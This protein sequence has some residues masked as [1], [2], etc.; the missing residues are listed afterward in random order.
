MRIEKINE[1]KIK[2]LIDDKEAEMWNVSFKKISQNT[3]EAQRVLWTAIRAAE[4][5][6]HFSVAGAKLFVEAVEGDMLSKFGMLI[7]KVANEEELND[8]IKN[9]SYKGTLRRSRL[10]LG[11]ERRDNQFIYRFCDFESVCNAA[12]EIYSIYSGESTLYKYN[13]E[14]YLHLIPAEVEVSPV[15]NILTEFG[16]CVKN[17][18]YIH[19]RLNEYGETMIESSALKILQ[20]YFCMSK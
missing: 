12:E 1:N 9:C 2:V 18:A 13:E 5:H 11:P 17:C 6:A 4:E 20:E 8:A 10:N 3:P 7:T 16:E 19:G 15:L 14:F